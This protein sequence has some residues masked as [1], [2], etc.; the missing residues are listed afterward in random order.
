MCVLDVLT[1]NRIFTL[2]TY[3]I[4]RALHEARLA[5]RDNVFASAQVC[6]WMLFVHYH[7]CVPRS[8]S[9]THT[10]EGLD[11]VLL[12]HGGHRFLLQERHAGPPQECQYP[13]LG[14][15]RALAARQHARQ[16]HLR[17]S[18]DF[19]GIRRD[20]QR[21]LR[22]TRGVDRRDPGPERGPA[23]AADDGHDRQQVRHGASAHGQAREIAS[24]RRR[25]RLSLSGHVGANGNEQFSSANL[26]YAILKLAV[27]CATTQCSTSLNF[28]CSAMPH[29]VRCAATR[30]RATA[31]GPTSAAAPAWAASSAPPRRCPVERRVSTRGPA[32][33]ASPCARTTT[34]DVQPMEFVALKVCNAM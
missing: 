21:E 3:I 26:K 1:L 13:A 34:G 20:E 6:L 11:T 33:P 7:A 31:S 30:S 29:V 14:R 10:I 18:P 27:R 22:H 15:Q 25:A 9:A 4:P 23:G 32:S 5:P 28:V 24:V 16:V 12:A 2:H 8:V 17:G 19:V